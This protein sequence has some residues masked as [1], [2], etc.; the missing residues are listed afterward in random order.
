MRGTVR[1][2]V[3]LLGLATLG[4]A[5]TW[6]ISSRREAGA[7]RMRAQVLADVERGGI[8][9]LAR[10]QVMARRLIVTNP[11]DAET[12]AA[13]AFADAILAVDYGLDTGREAKALLARHSGAI[14]TNDVVTGMLVAARALIHVAGGDR[15]GAVRVAVTGTAAA[16]GVA[17]PFY[18]L[19]RA[20]ALAG[21]L[22]GATRAL[23]AAIVRAPA[24]FAARLAWAEARM[25]QGDAK[26]ARSALQEVVSKAPDHLRAR[27]MLDEAELALGVA[28]SD[29]PAAC[30]FEDKPTAAPAEGAATVGA[31]A[32]QTLAATVE[33]SRWPPG[34]IRA[35]CALAA[36]TRARQAGQRAE[37][38][39]HVERAAGVVPN[40]ARL[41]GRTVE[42]LAQMGLVDW[43]AALLERTRK[44]GAPE[45]PALAWASLAIV[46][47]R[48]RVPTLPRGARP[49]DPESR[50]LV[51][52]AS[53][54]AGGA[55]AVG[56]VLASWPPAL[57]ATDRDLVLLTRLGPA[58]E[59][60]GPA[61]G[62]E[63]LRDYVD[64]LRAKLDGDLPKAAEK[65]S[66]AL[67]GHGDACRAAGEYIATMAILKRSVP[68]AVLTPLK[69]ENSGCVNLR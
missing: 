46:V 10:A 20:R 30:R 63:P 21:D 38:S 51:A 1:A 34:A 40:E 65:F 64:G 42:T 25:D 11:D 49:V 24:F 18:A 41:L 57:V 28:P 35:A 26:S 12:G 43:G 13:L 6:L 52:R 67:S 45:M 8:S 5:V 32:A 16:P 2:L 23:E 4:T 29:L 69:A 50:L 53:L 17:F 68:P 36:A 22:A 56:A 54:A 31:A 14:G 3:V 33:R 15:E 55:G 37:A 7:A 39:A 48:G 9:E 62:D 19:G 27:V 44:L 59:A 66:R 58:R 47:G 61:R 60:G